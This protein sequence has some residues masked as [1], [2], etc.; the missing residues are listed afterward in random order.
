MI[1]RDISCH[2]K[3][4]RA[5]L[6]H[7]ASWRWGTRLAKLDFI[8]LAHYIH[9]C[10]YYSVLAIQGISSCTCAVSLLF[11]ESVCTVL[12]I[13]GISLVCMYSV[14]TIQGISLC[15]YIMS[16]L[17]KESVW[18]ACTVSL[19]FKESVWCACTVS[20]LFK[21]SVCVHI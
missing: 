21:E 14:L 4:Y 17:F 3:L 7:L 15:T 8:V 13:Q 6:F 10:L 18:C 2:I 12:T 11:K 9:V 20:L 1:Y 5:L 19:L 16:L